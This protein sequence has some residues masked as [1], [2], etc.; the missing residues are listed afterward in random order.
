MVGAQVD[1]NSN[2]PDSSCYFQVDSENF[3]VNASKDVQSNLAP[4]SSFSLDNQS[5]K[6][7]QAFFQGAPSLSRQQTDEFEMRDL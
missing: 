5:N 7:Q 2:T 6:L 3:L 1:K 4:S